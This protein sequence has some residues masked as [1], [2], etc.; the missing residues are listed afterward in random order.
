MKLNTK[1]IIILVLFIFIVLF[2]GV[3][4]YNTKKNLDVKSNQI[5][6]LEES[7]KNKK[8]QIKNIHEKLSQNDISVEDLLFKN[9]INFKQIKNN[10]IKID[11]E[12]YNL[13]ILQSKDII[14]AKHPSASSSAYLDFSNEYLFLV[15]AT[16]QIVYSKIAELKNNEFNMNTIKSNIKNIITYPE[17]FTSSGFGIKDILIHQN[18]LY[19]SYVNENSSDCYSTGI[20]KASIDYQKLNF[21]SFYNSENCID[22]NNKFYE[23]NKHDHFV[24]HQAGGRMSIYKN[25][26]L[27]TVGE[28]RY[29]LLA[30]DQSNDFGKII[31][32]NLTNK[33]KKIISLGHRNPQGLFIDKKVNKILSTEH[34]P[35]GGDEINII[36]DLDSKISQLNEPDNF[37]WPIASYGDHYFQIKNDNRL[38]LSPLKK[39][40]S[41]NGFIE[42]IKYF[43]PSVAISQIVGVP[44]KFNKTEKSQYAVGT[45]GT[46]KKLEQGMLSIYFF[47]YDYDIKKITKSE[48]IKIKSRIRDIVYSEKENIMV[49]YL[50][51]FNAIGIISIDD[52]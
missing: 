26:L 4:A 10:E 23:S 35:S 31:S 14:F 8:L 44:N 25:H 17:F 33:D 51:T 12:D 45:M 21:S 20:L 22:T 41:D 9:G 18:K 40:H 42:P 39:S 32:I 29:R 3:S 49:M 16:G 34:G 11:K 24:A 5:E 46:A 47:E 13:K 1:S 15:T 37:G 6:F 36:D 30:Q 7:L 50:E 27:L 28:Y 48:F 43:V 2:I 38:K 19:L 52:I